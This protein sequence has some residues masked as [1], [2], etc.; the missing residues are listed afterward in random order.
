MPTPRQMATSS[1]PPR[2]DSEFAPELL[3]Q[4]RRRVERVALSARGR[5]PDTVMFLSMTELQEVFP[6]LS[7]VEISGLYQAVRAD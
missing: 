3:E 1:R 6:S 7:E 5:S 4:A 2:P